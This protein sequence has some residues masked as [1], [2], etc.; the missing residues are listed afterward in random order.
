MVE[1]T[2][3][4]TSE[5]GLHARPATALVNAVNS[6]T[7]DVNLEANGRT[8]NLKSIMGVMSLGIS[9]GTQV[10]ISASGSDEKAALEAVER[11]ITTEG[12]GE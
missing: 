4:I 10:K 11:A 3:T 9:K 1:K 7:A 2:F 12:L 8:V 6:F 5:A